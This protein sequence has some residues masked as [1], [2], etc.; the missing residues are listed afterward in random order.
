MWLPMFT[1]MAL[2]NIPFPKPSFGSSAINV[3][4]KAF[5]GVLLSALADLFLE[6]IEQMKKGSQ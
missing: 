6:T 1:A 3:L 2:P 5:V 4:Y